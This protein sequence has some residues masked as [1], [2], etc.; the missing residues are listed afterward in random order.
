MQCD[1][2]MMYMMYMIYIYIYDVMFCEMLFCNAFRRRP[3][4]T[5]ERRHKNK[6][7][8]EGRDGIAGITEG[9]TESSPM[10]GHGPLTCCPS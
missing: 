9:E 10:L 1:H 6:E 8:G 4:Y 3:R 5:G 2:D 7:T